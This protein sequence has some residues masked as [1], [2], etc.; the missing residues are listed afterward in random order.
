MSRLLRQ[1]RFALADLKGDVRRFGLLLACLALGTGLVAAVGSV[2]ANLERTLEREAGVLLGGDIEVTQEGEPIDAALVEQ[3]RS[4]GEVAEV[5]DTNARASSEG[6]NALVDLLAAGSTYPLI[7]TISSPQLSPGVAL[8]AFLAERDGMSGVLADPVL[9]QRLSVGLGSTVRIG[10]TPFEVRGTLSGVPDG[11]VRGVRLGL[12]ALIPLESYNTLATRDIPL[13]GL[14]PLYRYKIRLGED[15][16]VPEALAVLEQLSASAEWQVRT[17]REAI[18][19]LVEYYDL[20]ARYLLLIGLAAVL[21]GGSGVSQV[22]T[23]YMLERQRSVATMRALGATGSRLLVH[24]MAQIVLLAIIGVGI[25]VLAGALLSF[26]LLTPLSAAIGFPL[27]GTLELVPLAAATGF[28]LLASALFAY[29][30][31]LRAQQISPGVLFRSAVATLPPMPLRALTGLDI[32]LPLLVAGSAAIALAYVLTGDLALTLGAAV[33]AGLVL[34]VLQNVS[35]LLQFTLGL[36]RP[37]KAWVRGLLRGATAP[38][39]AAAATIVSVGMGLTLLLSM[40]LVVSSLRAELIDAVVEDAPS[41]I[42]TDLFSDE[43][44][45]LQQFAQDGQIDWVLATPMLRGRVLRLDDKDVS[46]A[47]SPEAR[48]L[49]SG[50][51]PLGMERELPQGSRIEAGQWWAADYDGPPLVSLPSQLQ[52]ELG[53]EV[54]DVAEFELFGEV[55]Q[56]SI[57]SFREYRFQ[58]GLN[59]AVAFSP[60]FIEQYPLTYLASIKVH[61]GEDV[62]V[63]QALAAEFPDV[64]FVP[65][66]DTIAQLSSALNQLAGVVL[67]AGALALTNGILVLIGATSTGRKQ[68]EAEAVI[69]K[70]LGATRRELLTSEAIYFVGLAI[71]AAVFAMILGIVLAYL[72]AGNV[73]GIALSLDA[74]S[75]LVVAIGAV[76]LVTVVGVLNT[77]R[78]LSVSPS[79]FLRGRV[80]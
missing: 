31:L 2:S 50:D 65:V 29:L 44:E 51:I 47:G 53:L 16:A 42:A 33:A 72:V 6:Q 48:F 22:V 78:I 66:G 17:A 4:L 45:T 27:R 70:V 3:F 35:K 28:G 15:L 25:G 52:R 76:L 54:G 43:V 46:S 40:V 7:G 21:I 60:G 19:P 9:L 39:S 71:Y 68:R 61:P 26:A 13:P 67:A 10:G 20:F 34:L 55:V 75:L 36:V 73:L 69:M 32:A 56:A 41:L 79:Q 63:Q 74:T 5:V 18:G 24:Y 64:N 37:G 57:A 1:I 77:R 62:P 30:P 49:F 58:E 38:G 14:S 8:D 59:F 23:A 11:P 80:L 12:T